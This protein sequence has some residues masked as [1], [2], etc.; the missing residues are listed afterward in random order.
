MPA[1]SLDM[2]NG[3]SASST[4][5]S[6]L[7]YTR[8]TLTTYVVGAASCRRE[9][10]K[11]LLTSS[12]TSTQPHFNSLPLSSIR[13][14]KPFWTSTYTSPMIEFKPLPSTREQILTTA[15]IFLLFILTT[16]SVLSLTA[17]SYACVDFAPTTMTSWLNL[18]IW[19]HSLHSVVIMYF[20]W[21]WST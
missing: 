20:P 10:L 1:Y 4:Q 6:Y 13:N 11:P 14:L 17:S 9:E 15:S 3:K 5:D 18:K 19:Q 12:L 8:G 2:W 7:S 21:A 16:A